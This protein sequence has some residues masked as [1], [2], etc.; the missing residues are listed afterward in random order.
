MSMYNS[1]AGHSTWKWILFYTIYV[2]CHTIFD[3]LKFRVT[4]IILYSYTIV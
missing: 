4:Y 1:D 3:T 2:A